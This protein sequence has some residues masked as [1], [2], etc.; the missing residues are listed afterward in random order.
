[1]AE[2]QRLS[3][4]ALF[5]IF[6]T[7]AVYFVNLGSRQ[8]FSL[9][10]PQIKTEFALSDG[11]L[12]LLAGPAF[13][14]VFSLLTIPLGMLGDR[15]NRRNLLAIGI[16]IFSIMSLLSGFAVQFWQL[17]L[18]RVGF[19]AIQ[20]IFTPS[21]NSLIA[22]VVPRN[23]R[24]TA[25]AI[26]A[27]GSRAGTISFALVCGWIAAEYGWRNAV[28]A[29]GIPG[30]VLVLF[31][32][33]FVK[34]P[35]R[36]AVENRKDEKKAPAFLPTLRLLFS[37]PTY[38]NIL[39]SGCVLLF[40][41]MPYGLFLPTVF[42]RVHGVS[43]KD[44]TFIITGYNISVAAGGYL[45][46][47]LSDRLAAGKPSRLLSFPGTLQLVVLPFFI[48]YL[49]T[50]NV[51]VAIVAGA[52]PYSIGAG[53]FIG[54]VFAVTQA[55]SPLRARGIALAIY[56]FTSS[57]FGSTLA[58]WIIGI[59]SDW[60]HPAYGIKS[61]PYALLVFVIP[62]HLFGTWFFW[63]AS[64]TLEADTARASAA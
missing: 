50:D 17:L 6:I 38:R 40:V 62:A 9:I 32:L 36:G 42:T 18:T 44:V 52:V 19:G 41:T 24:A 26:T 55:V 53:A 13:G 8:V 57:L 54:P 59:V 7:T 63:R 14:L 35:A 37:T 51:W 3:A 21:I 25:I 43:L 29:A 33:A 10:L 5:I 28:I 46:G 34:E 15:F 20:G 61:L 23:R 48:L 56:V 45:V 30:L 49:V 12:G 64:R 16:A 47:F 11:D 1:M 22:D 2:Q 31:M 39:L 27:A 58:P 60:M 4:Y